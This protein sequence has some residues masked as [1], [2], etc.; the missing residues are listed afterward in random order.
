MRIHQLLLLSHQVKLLVNSS[1]SSSPE[2][3]INRQP[4]L[5]A[6]QPCQEQAILNTELQPIQLLK[7]LPLNKAPSTLRTSSDRMLPLLT[8]IQIQ[9]H[10]FLV[11]NHAN[12][13]L[14]SNSVLLYQPQ[15]QE[16][17]LEQVSEIIINNNKPVELD[18]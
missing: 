4:L 12:H 2:F 10:Q 14:S 16:V 8:T 18:I 3:S 5:V 17:H 13:T 15:L 11:N 1:N 6:L 9:Q 7:Q